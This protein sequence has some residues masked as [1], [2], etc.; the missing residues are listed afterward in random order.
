MLDAASTQAVRM[1]VKAVRTRGKP[2]HDRSGS[3]C[4]GDADLRIFDDR[5]PLDRDSELARGMEIEVGRGL[6]PL[7]MFAAAVDMTSER[8]GE[9][10]MIEMATEPPHGARRGDRFGQ[11]RR[12]R[13]DEI[14]G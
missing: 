6:A 4:A 13:T 2:D 11:L 5:G 7:D 12:E 14:D 10:E 3:E 1:P 8:L 9:A